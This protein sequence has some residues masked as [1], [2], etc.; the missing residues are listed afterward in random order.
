MATGAERAHHAGEVVHPIVDHGNHSVPLVDGTP[1]TRGSS[2]VAASSA[3]GERLE[4]RLDDVVRVVAPDQVEMHRQPGVEHQSAEE[5]R[6]EK[7]IVVAQHLPLRNVDVVRQI[8]T[9]GDVHHTAHQRLIERHH[10]VGVAANARAVT[11]RLGDGLAQHDAGVFDGVMPVDVQIAPRLDRQ[12]QQ[13]VAGKRLEH[14]VEEADPGFHLGLAGP[15]QV[16][17][18]VEIG[19]FGLAG[20]LTYSGHA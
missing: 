18:D 11:Q 12:V 1:V 13:T 9:P 17:P 3:P 16:H 14:V 19:L 20:H 2:A 4:G 6:R 7:H 5:L 15:V 10:R 8:G